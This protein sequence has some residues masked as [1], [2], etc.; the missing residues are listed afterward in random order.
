MK[1]LFA[2]VP[3]GPVLA[4]VARVSVWKSPEVASSGAPDLLAR[5][6]VP[7]R[8]AMMVRGSATVGYNPGANVW[9]RLD[10]D[11]AEVLRWLRAGRGRADLADHLHRRFG[12]P[13]AED[14]L[15]EI[16]RWSVLRQMLYLEVGPTVPEPALPAHPLT[17]LYWICTQACN[18]RCTYCYQDA[19]VARPGELTTSEGF[20]LIDQ[21][22]EAGVQTLVFTGG[23][24]F[25]R[26]D[27]LKLARR[28]SE[29]GLRTNVITN[30]SHITARRAAEIAG[31]FDKITVSLDHG[32]PDH[33]DRVRGRGSWRKAAQAIDLLLAEGATVDVNSVLTAAGLSDVHELLAYVRGRR[34]GQHRIIP[35][36]PMG[37]GGEA[38]ADELPAGALLDLADT[39]HRVGDTDR[40]DLV[41]PEAATTSK[42]IRRSHCGAGLSEVS[43]DPEGWVYPCKLLQDDRY[44][45]G[46]VRD[47]RLRE[48]FM[49][50][51]AITDFHRPFVSTL[52]P[53]ITCVVKN[54]C[55]GGCRGIHASFSG[56]WRVAEPLFCAQLRREFEVMVFAT[57]GHVPSRRPATFVRSDGAMAPLGARRQELAFVPLDALRQRLVGRP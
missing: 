46:N 3:A 9:H 17:T 53:C 28:S 57:T 56:D 7:A 52:Q 15:D 24:P 19:T 18:L 38:R 35:Q 21:A 47:R 22:V 30:G 14:R 41:E 31:I 54:H 29:S 23:E 51:P 36:Y 42:G 49:T 27:L 39:L 37:R 2:A 45:A 44:R 43:V 8:L 55:G 33:H 5:V 25:S 6:T 32:R 48:I 34:I 12:T 50:D 20:D 11:V 10:D 13:D 1:T 4:P 26:R 40:S 16:L